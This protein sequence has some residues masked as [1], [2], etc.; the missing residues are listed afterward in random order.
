MNMSD[1]VSGSMSLI[2]PDYFIYCHYTDDHFSF[3]CDSVDVKM[4][5]QPRNTNSHLSLWRGKAHLAFTF[6]R[7]NFK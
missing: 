4:E 7:Y 1:H 5:N 3:T 6:S 2:A